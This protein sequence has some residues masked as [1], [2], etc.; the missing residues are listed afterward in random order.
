MSTRGS[1]R[2]WHR[3]PFFWIGWLAGGLS[4]VFM[5]GLILLVSGVLPAWWTINAGYAVA[6]APPVV[7]A[8]WAWRALRR[9]SAQER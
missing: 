3:Q 9:R 2:I 4:S 8:L 7:A 5:V 6:S 1:H